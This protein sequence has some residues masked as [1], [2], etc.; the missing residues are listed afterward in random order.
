MIGHASEAWSIR[1]R[2]TVPDE[3]MPTVTG[4]EAAAQHRRDPG[5]DRLLAQAGRVEVDVHVDRACGGDH[6][7]GR[8]DIGVRADDHPCI[9]AVHRL[10]VARLADPDDP[11]V[12]DADVALDDPRARRRSRPR[13]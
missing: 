1:P 11:A 10:R 9:D 8:P 12:L 2:L 6:P 5:R 3:V 13:S 4:P 7:L